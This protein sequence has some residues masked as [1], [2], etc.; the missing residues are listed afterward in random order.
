M[1]TESNEIRRFLLRKA[2][3]VIPAKLSAH[4][5][6]RQPESSDAAPSM[7]GVWT[8]MKLMNFH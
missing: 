6:K 8:K 5:L 4:A 1:N 7:D 3:I 2:T